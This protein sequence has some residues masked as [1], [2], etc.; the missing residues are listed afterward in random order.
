[1][2]WRLSPRKPRI[3]GKVAFG[4]IVVGYVGLLLLGAAITAIG[5][6]TV[7]TICHDRR[8]GVPVCDGGEVRDGGVVIAAT[9]ADHEVAGPRRPAAP[10]RFRA[11]PG[12]ERARRAPFPD[13]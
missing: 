10:P 9:V 12:R 2:G 6:D 7:I 1:M 3:Q 13:R 5:M 11:T 4:H 8:S